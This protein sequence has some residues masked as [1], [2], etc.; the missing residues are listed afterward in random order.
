MT[1]LKIEEMIIGR[2]NTKYLEENMPQSHFVHHES[3]AACS[4]I[5]P[6]SPRDK[7]AINRLSYRP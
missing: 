6:G 4:G 3:N 5:A 1:E 2:G 7:P